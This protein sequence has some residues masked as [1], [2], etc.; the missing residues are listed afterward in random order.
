MSPASRNNTYGNECGHLAR[1]REALFTRAALIR[2]VRRFFHDHD[3]L[4]VD[5]PNRVPSIAPEVHIDGVPSGNWFLHTSPELCMKRLVAAGYHSIFQISKCYRHGERGRYHL[6]EFSLLEWYRAGIDYRVLMDECEEMVRYAVTEVMGRSSFVFHG[7]AVAVDGSWE[8]L[9]VRAAFERYAACSADEA[10]VADT[11]DDIMTVIIEP[12]LGTP[13]PTFLYDY[14]SILASLARVKDDDPSVA[15][16]CELYMA[17]VEL[18]NGFSELTDPDEQRRRFDSDNARRQDMGKHQHPPSQKFL[19]ALA[20]MPGTA[21]IALGIDRLV[22]IL[23]DVERIDDVVT[24]TP[25][26]L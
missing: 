16:R 21:G 26:D 22:M 2:A 19:A 8:R 1:K 23:A 9:T 14:P 25:E 20:A 10:I 11:F 15:E 7:R 5:T 24:F 12:H 18:A 17:G 3:Y 6:P 13:R 4:E